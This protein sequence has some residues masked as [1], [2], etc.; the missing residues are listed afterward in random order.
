M[1]ER[2]GPEAAIELIATKSR[3]SDRPV[4]TSG[5]TSGANTIPENSVRPR[6]RPRLTSVTAASVPSTVATVAES[7]PTR[8]VTQAASSSASFCKSAA[9]HCV[10]PG[11]DVAVVVSDTHGRPWRRGN[12]GVAVGVAGLE[13]LVDKA[14]AI[15]LFGRE[16]K[17]TMI[18]IADQLAGAAALVSGE[19]DEGLPVVIVRGAAG[20]PRRRHLRRPH[21]P[22]GLRPLR[23]TRSLSFWRRR[24]VV[25]QQREAPKREQ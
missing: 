2:H 20:R 12:V 19:T 3:S 22:P 18:P 25:R 11:V 16:L 24:Y 17:A 14:G 7:R 15:D 9:Y 10:D 23:L 8:N 1:G 4:I 13:P 6:K 5:M 21:L